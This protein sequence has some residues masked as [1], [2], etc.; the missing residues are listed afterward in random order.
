VKGN[1]DEAVTGRL[2]AGGD[3]EKHRQDNKKQD[4]DRTHLLDT[5][6]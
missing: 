5:L 4:D 2:G 3:R 1:G 6:A